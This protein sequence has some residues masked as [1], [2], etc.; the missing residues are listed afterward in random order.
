MS[1]TLEAHLNPMYFTPK[2]GS[3][4]ASNRIRSNEKFNFGTTEQFANEIYSIVDYEDFR[5][6]TEFG[7]ARESIH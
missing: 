3:R 7:D 4:I 2:N 1:S 5:Q 6:F